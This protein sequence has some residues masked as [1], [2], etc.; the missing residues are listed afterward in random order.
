MSLHV[1]LMGT[2]TRTQTSKA[3]LSKAGQGTSSLISEPS[4]LPATGRTMRRTQTL[5]H[6]D[7]TA[8]YVRARLTE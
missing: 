6:D 1:D 5:L 8:L 4:L 3:Y 2:W 7:T